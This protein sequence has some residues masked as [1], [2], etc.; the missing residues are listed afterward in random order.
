[1]TLGRSGIKTM[2]IKTKELLVA[3]AEST[4]CVE[5]ELFLLEDSGGNF[6]DA[7]R[8]G[9]EDGEIL[10]ARKLLEMENED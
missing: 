4:R 8:M 3:L 10:L 2:K 5:M 6:D 7:W 9:V 1:M